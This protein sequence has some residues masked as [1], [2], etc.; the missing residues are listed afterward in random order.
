LPLPDFRFKRPR[1]FPRID[2][3][4]HATPFPGEQPAAQ[5]LPFGKRD[6][7]RTII[8]F[9]HIIAENQP[10]NAYEK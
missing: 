3:A 8:F 10:N 6:L 9:S 5:S 7:I 2:N 4:T 1:S